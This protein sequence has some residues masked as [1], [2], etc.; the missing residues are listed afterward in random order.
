MAAKAKNASEFAMDSSLTI[1]V[2]EKKEEY[3]GPTVSVYLPEIE[4]GGEEGVK[5]DQYEHVSI[6]NENKETIYY[7]LRGERVDV[8]VAVFIALK[9]KYGKRL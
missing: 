4:G 6:A 8:P 3:T 5:V 2:P 9:E 1:A 7:V